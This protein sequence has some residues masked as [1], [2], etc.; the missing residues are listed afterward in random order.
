MIIDTNAALKLI[1]KYFS[2]MKRKSAEL[3]VDFIGGQAP[4]AY[5]EE[6]RLVNFKKL[7]NC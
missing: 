2:K 4:M 6:K 7:V 5:E 3:D 1:N